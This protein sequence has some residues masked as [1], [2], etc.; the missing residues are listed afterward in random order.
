MSTSIQFADRIRERQV[1]P[2]RLLILPT[3]ADRVVSWR[4][5]FVANPDLA[6]GDD[7][8]QELTVSLLD[9]G[10]EQRD[11]FELA[12]VLE[13]CGAKLNLSSDG[14]YVDFAGRALPKDVPQVLDV[15]AE[16][17]AAPAFDD[18]EFQKARA[19]AAAE[20]QRNMDDTST[21]AA[22]AL[23]RRLYPRA[24]PNYSERPQD[25]LAA[26]QELTIDDVRR[27]HAEHFGAHELTLAV[28]GDLDPDAIKAAVQESLGDWADHDAPSAHATEAA[29]SD[30]GRETV[31]LP[32][33]DNI[34]V[35]MG[36]ALDLRRDDPDYL[37]FYVGN[38]ILGGNFSARLMATVR[39][40]KGLTYG[41]SSSLSGVSTQYT[42]HWHVG[43]TLS[44]DKL[45]EGIEAT[46]KT[47]RRF[48][49]EGAT[50]DELDA[51]KT[52]ITGSY[53]VGLATTRRLAQSILTNA[54][55]GFD[56]DYLDRFPDEINALTLDDVNDAVR[57]H[58]RPDA[59]HEALA[60]TLPEATPAA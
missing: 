43:V 58:L 1:G 6:A 11:R 14:L 12:Q 46:Q 5:S 55:R 27:Y 23:S 33:K 24:H 39:D 60:G 18:A 21:Q 19:Q 50:A 56:V 53:K 3:D 10:T 26:L 4:G 8:R 42:G 59:L 48:V 34:D 36:H 52:T 13:D 9:K 57:R 20:I 29:P 38:Y 25:Q 7:L 2:C 17:L 47:V 16:M 22:G 44:Q 15:M 40:E 41:I 45:D 35:R 31:P 54:E 32:D 37:P 51:K 28:V 30:P 49:E